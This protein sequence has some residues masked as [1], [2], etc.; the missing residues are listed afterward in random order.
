MTTR[1]RKARRGGAQSMLSILKREFPDGKLQSLF[2]GSSRVVVSSSSSSIIAADPVFIHFSNGG[3]W[4]LHFWVK[5]LWRRNRF[6][7]QENIGSEFAWTVFCF[8]TIDLDNSH[9]IAI[10]TSPLSLTGFFTG[11]LRRRC[12]QKRITEKSWNR[13]SS[14]R[15]FSALWCLMTIYDGREHNFSTVII[16][17]IQRLG[18]KM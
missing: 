8:L 10:L 9:C 4:T 13:A 5:S 6:Y 12:F 18:K 11:M 7:C 14:F 17:I 2:Q 3:C 15:G 16:K 1:K